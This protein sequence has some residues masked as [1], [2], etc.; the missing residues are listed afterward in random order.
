[1][2]VNFL[3]KSRLKNCSKTSRNMKYSKIYVAFKFFKFQ[4]EIYFTFV[5]SEKLLHST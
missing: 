3:S 2:I 1:M 4:A 5:L